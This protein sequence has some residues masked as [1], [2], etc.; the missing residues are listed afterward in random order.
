MVPYRSL[1]VHM[2]FCGFLLVLMRPYVSLLVLIGLYG[3][4]K[5]LMHCYAFLWVLMCPYRSLCVLI[6]F[7]GS[8][9]HRIF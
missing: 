9:Y 4:L 3:S 5:V 7:I 1:C 8:L 2:L 6:D